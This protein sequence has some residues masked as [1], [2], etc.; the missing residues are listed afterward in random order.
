MPYQFFL[1]LHRHHT[2]TFFLFLL[3]LYLGSISHRLF[4]LAQPPSAGQS[5]G[6]TLPPL[7]ESVHDKKLEITHFI[8]VYKTKGT[9]FSEL[10]QTLL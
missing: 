3:S 9:L 2:Q 4:D 5:L 8:T 10:Q 1:Q 7:S 6:L